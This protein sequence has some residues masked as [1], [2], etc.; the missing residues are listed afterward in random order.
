M[1]SRQAIFDSVVTQMLAQKRKSMIGGKCKYRGE[2]GLKCA[3]GCVLPD[4]V[5]TPDLEVGISGLIAKLKKRY[6]DCEMVREMWRDE[7]LLRSLQR[8]HDYQPPKSWYER[9]GL[10]A[11]KYGLKMPTGLLK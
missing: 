6:G 3:V 7:D 11:Y 8:V 4:E 1:I 10:V 9:F 5:Y 2:N